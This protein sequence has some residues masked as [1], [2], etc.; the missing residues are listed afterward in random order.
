MGKEVSIIIH[1][2]CASSYRLVKNLA[3]K[4]LVSR[5]KLVDVSSPRNFT[6]LRPWSV[7]WVLVGGEPV[8]ADPTNVDEVLQIINNS[9][10]K[11]LDLEEQFMKTVLSSAYASSLSYLWG[12]T[13]IVLEDSFIEAAV[14]AKLL[15][16]DVE[17][18]RRILESRSKELYTKWEK[19]IVK[20]L[21]YVFVREYWWSAEGKTSAQEIREHINEEVLGVWL[22]GKASIGRVGL[23]PRPLLGREKTSS[24]YSTVIANLEKILK[25]VI[26]EQ[27]IILGDKEYWRILDKYAE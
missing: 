7:P 21:A 14:R 11:Q 9:W 10:R 22:L 16:L 4:N 12:D 8:A 18:I 20:T 26:E 17:K 23:P 15:G 25:H 5:V 27:T 6:R 1:P 13:S 24:L 2:T 19:K 3:E